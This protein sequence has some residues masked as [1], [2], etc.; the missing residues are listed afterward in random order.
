MTIY[1]C[2]GAAATQK[3]G[4]TTMA[5][6]AIHTDSG[7]APPVVRRHDASAAPRASGAIVVVL[8]LGQWAWRPQQILYNRTHMASPDAGPVLLHITNP[9]RHPR[10]VTQ[11]KTHLPRTRLYE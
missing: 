6:A 7:P 9:K 11:T 5:K 1:L 4:R 3:H 2:L 8:G 10:T